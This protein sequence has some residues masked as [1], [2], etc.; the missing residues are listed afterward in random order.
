MRKKRTAV[1]NK[2]DQIYMSPEAIAQIEN[3]NRI[4]RLVMER[5]IGSGWDD[6]TS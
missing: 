6:K 5:S 3:N 4:L 1:H 2:G